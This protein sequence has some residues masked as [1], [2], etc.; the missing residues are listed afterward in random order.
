MM[1]NSTS[2]QQPIAE[3]ALVKA[4][5]SSTERQLENLVVERSRLQQK[6]DGASGNARQGLIAQMVPM[7]SS[8]DNSGAMIAR[9]QVQA[10]E[11]ERVLGAPVAVVGMP[12]RDLIFGYNKPEFMALSSMVLLLPLV[13]AFAVRM[14]RG[15]ARKRV[16]PMPSFMDQDRLVRLEQ[17]MDAMAVEI[18]RIGE[19]QRYQTKLMSERR[20]EVPRVNTPH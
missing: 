9:L 5:L 8:I 1:Q 19:G 20:S 14:A 18:E 17:A 6:I 16:E 3:L 12:P 7:S 11:L 2:Q 4:Q 15:G 13:I 10:Q